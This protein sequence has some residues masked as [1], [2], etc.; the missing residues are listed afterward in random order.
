MKIMKMLSQV[1]E[2][3]KGRRRSVCAGWSGYSEV[4]RYGK[5]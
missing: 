5:H 4:Y 2:E 1:L 3:D